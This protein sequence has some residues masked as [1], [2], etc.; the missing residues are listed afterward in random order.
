[1]PV[2]HRHVPQDSDVQKVH[3]NRFEFVFYVSYVK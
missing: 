3:M 2:L 1:M